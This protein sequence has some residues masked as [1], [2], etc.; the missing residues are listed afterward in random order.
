MTDPRHPTADEA[1]DLP[2]T[3]AMTMED[4][5]E[6]EPYPGPGGPQD[7]GKGAEPDGGADR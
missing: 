1:D 2:D 4:T 7:D 5:T 6:L 3:D